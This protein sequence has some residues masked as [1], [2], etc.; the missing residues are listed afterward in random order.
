MQLNKDCI[1][2]I[3]IYVGKHSIYEMNNIKQNQLHIVH[4]D[5]LCESNDL[6]YENDII[7]YALQK[8][9]EYN[10]IKFDSISSSKLHSKIDRCF[11]NYHIS[12]ITDRGHEFLDNIKQ[13]ED[14]NKIKAAIKNAG[15]EDCSLNI[16][17]EYIYNNM[18]E[19]ICKL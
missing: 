13:E 8:M 12:E 18:K 19:Q 9:V 10:L 5:E 6:Q 7:Y 4:F 2:D 14:W 3:L 1:R 11:T 15:K 16:Y 17:F